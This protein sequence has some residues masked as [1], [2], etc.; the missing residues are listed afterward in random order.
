MRE[1]TLSFVRRDPKQA[2]ERIPDPVP[3]PRA[4]VPTKVRVLKPFWL[5]RETIA[6]PGQQVT[7]PRWLAEDLIARKRAE[8][9]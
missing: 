5:D 7:V 3:D 8:R 1:G 2:A 9:V 4:Q 6:Q